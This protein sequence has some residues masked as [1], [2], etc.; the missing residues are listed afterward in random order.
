MTYVFG[1]GKGQTAIGTELLAL[2]VLTSC[3]GFIAVYFY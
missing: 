1:C 3:P 2:E